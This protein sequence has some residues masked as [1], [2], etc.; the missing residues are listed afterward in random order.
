MH[1]SLIDG[2][3]C[4]GIVFSTVDPSQGAITVYNNVFVNAG[5]GPATVEGGGTFSCIYA[6]GY[7][8]P[9]SRPG[10]GVIDV[11]NNTMYNCGAFRSGNGYGGVIY[12]RRDTTIEVRLRNNIIV[13]TNGT[14]YWTNFDGGAL[15]LSGS[16]NLVFG[17]GTA[18]AS[19]IT[20]TITSDP[21]FVNAGAGDFRLTPSSPARGAG[22]NTGLA[23]DRDGVLRGGTFDLGAYQ[24]GPGVGAG[25]G[26]SFTTSTTAL[27]AASIVGVNPANQTLTMTNSGQQP[28]DF[29]TTID[30]QWATVTPARGTLAAGANQ[31]LTVAFNLAGLDAGVYSGILRIGAGDSQRELSLRLTVTPISVTDPAVSLS[32][33]TLNYAVADP[34]G[35]LPPPQTF[36]LRNTGAPGS[37]LRWTARTDQPWATVSPAGGAEQQGTAGQEMTVRVNP[38]GFANGAYSATVFVE[39]EKALNSPARLAI[40]LGVGAPKIDSIV[41]AANF[42]AGGVAP[43]TLVSIF[44]VNLGPQDG[45]GFELTPDGRNVRMGTGVRVLFDGVPAAVLYSQ[46]SQVN[47]ILPREAGLRRSVQVTVDNGGL[48]SPPVPL[49]ITGTSPAVFTLTGTGSG[50]AAALNSDAT[51]NT[52]GNA[53]ARG[54]AVSFYL[55]GLGDLNPPPGDGEVLTRNNYGLT[56]NVSVTVGGQDCPVG[57]AGAAPGFVVGVYQVNCQ[58]PMGIATGAQAVVVRASGQPSA[59]AVTLSVR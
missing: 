35:A 52:P 34:N 49:E 39:A 38:E 53:A 23:T 31:L 47:A 30:R 46:A 48:V 50:A 25:G 57:Y 18:P 59:G 13:H 28:F 7:T 17:S 8:G 45:Q 12:A 21:L 4:D 37:I 3:Q 42:Q 56:V 33:S 44:G 43:R 15:G 14:A 2:T 20:N 24:S 16:N 55:T 11:Y 41:N 9:R 32:T 51:V 6:A 40:R 36:R 54:A 1:D 27:E 10:A 29:I 19:A 58:L 26:A 5:R 22:V